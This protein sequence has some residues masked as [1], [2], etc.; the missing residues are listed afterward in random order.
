MKSLLAHRH[1]LNRAQRALLV[2]GFVPVIGIIVN[3]F[4]PP[5]HSYLPEQCLLFVLAVA[6]FL[7]SF[8]TAT[9]AMWLYCATALLPVGAMLEYYQAVG[10]GF[11]ALELAPCLGVLLMAVLTLDG[12]ATLAYGALAMAA[13]GVLTGRIRGDVGQAG[14]LVFAAGTLTFC[15]LRWLNC[16]AQVLHREVEQLR[17]KTVELGALGNFIIQQQQELANED[18]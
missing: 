11:S 4:W 12:R 1:F 18:P 10:G 5:V 6:A 13:S 14:A 3:L 8:A 2:L 9:G 17:S 16:D 7:L 15:V